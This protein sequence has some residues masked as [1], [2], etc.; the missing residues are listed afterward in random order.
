MS[1]D[2]EFKELLLSHHPNLPYFQD[3]V[4]I[5]FNKRVCAGCLLAYPTAFF[6]LIIFHPFWFV[7]IFISLIFAVLSQFRRIYKTNPYFNNYCRFLAGIAFGFGIGGEIWAI[8][9]EHWIMCIFLGMGALLYFLSKFYVMNSI[10]E[11]H[12][13]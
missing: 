1:F 9:T 10:L 13:E 3:D 6:I 2:P 8:K 4:I 5:I 7:S 12:S 11:K